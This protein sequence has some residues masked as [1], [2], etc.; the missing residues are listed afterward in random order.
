MLLIITDECSTNED[1][2][3]ENHL[4]TYVILDAK[5]K[6]NF[7]ITPN[8]INTC[9]AILSSFVKSSSGIPIIATNAGK[10]TLRND[11]G[12]ASKVELLSIEEVTPQFI[13]CFIPKY[14]TEYLRIFFQENERNHTRLVAVANYHTEE[15]NANSPSSPEAENF[16]EATILTAVER[17]AKRIHRRGSGQSNAHSIS[18]AVSTLDSTIAQHRISRRTSP[19]SLKLQLNLLPRFIT[20]SPKSV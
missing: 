1:E 10:L 8:T 20:W 3:A 12:Y 6:L 15:S 14:H 11:I 13:F 4:A 18:F 9:S 7:T 2:I 16:P 17:Y 5:D 19:F